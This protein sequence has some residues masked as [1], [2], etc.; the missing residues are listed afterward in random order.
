MQK[1][2]FASTAEHLK[3][4]VP[5]LMK[6][7]VPATPTNYALWYTYVSNTDT[8]LAKKIDDSIEKSGSL[9]EKESKKL[10]ETYIEERKTNEIDGFKE[11]IQS[12]ATEISSTM[13]LTLKDTNTFQSTL[14]NTF[15]Q[16]ARVTEEALSM[17][18]TLKVVQKAVQGSSAV[19]ESTLFFKNQ[20]ADAQKEISRLKESLDKV[21]EK[22][23]QDAL[24]GLFNRRAFDTE[25]DSLCAA[26]NPFCLILCDLDHF[27]IF[28]DTYGHVKG[29]Q[30]LKL[31]SHRLLKYC[32]NGIK[33]FR[34]GGEEFAL[35]I[36]NQSLSGATQVGETIR[37]GIDK[38]VIKDKK[39]GST[40][41]NISIS[42]GVAQHEKEESAE[43]L[44][45]RTDEQLYK[46]KDLGRNCV[47]SSPLK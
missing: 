3:K 36:P 47:V 37:A 38:L 6:Y 34:Y 17:E 25:I 41:N 16:L 15:S 33:A 30:V 26:S 32:Q 8:P 11:S 40:L 19:Q 46:A 27:K 20:L 42:V 28:N 43:N 10:Y 14:E 5:L 24:T 21:S 9:S 4:V 7:Q 23:N 12:L 45:N 29:D 31:T 44:I 13:E 22:A 2:D 18:E 35:L 1:E 39:T